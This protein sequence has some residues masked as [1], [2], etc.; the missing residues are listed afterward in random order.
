MCHEVYEIVVIVEKCVTL[1]S[2]FK[3]P[4]SINNSRGLALLDLTQVRIGL[5]AR[6]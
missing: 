2:S 5:V 4:C 6:L 1:V 3:Q